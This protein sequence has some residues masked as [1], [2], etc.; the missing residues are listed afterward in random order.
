MHETCN[1]SL[2]I[3]IRNFLN[4]VDKAKAACKNTGL[5]VEDHFV[6][7]TEMVDIGSGSVR[8][9]ETIKLN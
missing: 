6:D 3:P 8:E 5:P 4:T 2:N 1:G 7:A 9:V